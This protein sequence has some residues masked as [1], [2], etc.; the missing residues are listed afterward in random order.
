M[1]LSDLDPIPFD[2]FPPLARP[3]HISPISPQY[4]ALSARLQEKDA[5]LASA[6]QTIGLLVSSVRSLEASMSRLVGQ[7][8]HGG[9]GSGDVDLGGATV[10]PPLFVRVEDDVS[11]KSESVG[12]IVVA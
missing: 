7:G 6:Q 12:L 5:E 1:C 8:P 11:A 10:P 2:S 3:H 9:S 4:Q